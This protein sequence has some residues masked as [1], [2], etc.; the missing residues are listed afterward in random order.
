MDF[1]NLNTY[2]PIC[3][4]VYFLFLEMLENDNKG[5]K[6]YYKS[7]CNTA[8]NFFIILISSE[9]TKLINYRT[10]MQ[11]SSGND[12]YHFYLYFKGHKYP[13]KKEELND[14]LR[15]LL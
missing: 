14:C 9:K 11:D 5:S 1:F 8:K 7:V 12:T 3:K 15:L 13:I 4:I 2:T 6:T 10:I